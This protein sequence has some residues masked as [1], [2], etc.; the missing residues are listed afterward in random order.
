[1]PSTFILQCSLHQK[2]FSVKA[3]SNLWVKF[4]NHK[5]AQVSREGCLHI[6]DFIKNCRK[7][8]E[9]SN[10]PQ[11][12]S[13]SYTVGGI[14][15]DPGEGLPLI[16]T[17]KTPLYLDILNSNQNI[18]KQMPSFYILNIEN[19]NLTSNNQTY[20]SVILDS[21]MSLNNK[22][23]LLNQFIIAK[24]LEKEVSAKEKEFFSKEYYFN[25]LII[26]KEKEASAKDK[27]IQL[28][29]RTVEA[30]K[31][32]IHRLLAERDFLKYNLDARHI[33]KNY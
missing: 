29:D 12:L 9:L 31:I 28:H 15:L 24:E 32:Q 3:Q 4:K 2:R 27:I 14:P 8:F 1:M 33:I 25:Q 20:I 21:N 5:T 18:S 16:N 26:A 23:L 17:F 30:L 19:E 10:Q 13:L 7:M 11:T 22:K 6:D